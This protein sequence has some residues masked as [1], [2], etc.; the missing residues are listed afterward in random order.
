MLKA[1]LIWYDVSKKLH[2]YGCQYAFIPSLIHL[3]RR[4][5]E[6]PCHGNSCFAE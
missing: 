2:L 6:R 5:E 4:K 3:V 1:N